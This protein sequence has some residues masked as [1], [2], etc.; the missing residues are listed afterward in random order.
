MEN[1]Y[2]K[3]L[4]YALKGKNL[5]IFFFGTIAL[6]F[7]TIMLFFSRMP[8]VVLFPDADPNYINVVSE[9]PVGTDITGTN[10]F[11][12]Q[13]EQDVIDYLIADGSLVLGDTNS[14]VESI[15]STVGKGDPNDFSASG[16][17]NKALLT[18]SFIDYELR[19]GASTSAIMQGISTNL[20]GK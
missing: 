15:L 14:I 11:M 20:L 9:L 6:M 19:N 12:K 8:E 3:S 7:I 2:E 16:S 17:P 10:E 18:I 5:L 1:F 13:L 4:R